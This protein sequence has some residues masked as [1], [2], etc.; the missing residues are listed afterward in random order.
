MGK[1]ICI[2]GGDGYLGWPSAMR[3]SA[4]GYDVTVVDNYLRRELCAQYGLD[5][6]YPVPRLKQRVALWEAVSGRRIHLAELDLA[7][8]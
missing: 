5:F 3:F 4:L 8:P 6:L 7:D 1:H 2:L